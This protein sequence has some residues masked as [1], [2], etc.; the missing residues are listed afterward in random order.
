MFSA[1]MKRRIE[2]DLKKEELN[3]L[4]KLDS[5]HTKSEKVEDGNY[6]GLHYLITKQKYDP[7]NNSYPALGI[8]GERGPLSG[9]TVVELPD[10]NGD[11]RLLG[12][13]ITLADYFLFSLNYNTDKDFTP[14]NKVGKKYTVKEI[15][16]DAKAFIDELVR[17]QK[18]YESKKNL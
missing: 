6:K 1:S 7:H 3:E 17:L 2:G 10:R 15:I 14:R 12:R 8:Y 16:E 13:C 11:I 5:N 4:Y 18:E 9:L